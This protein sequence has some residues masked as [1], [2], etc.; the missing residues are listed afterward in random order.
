MSRGLYCYMI[1]T[2]NGN[3]KGDYDFVGIIIGITNWL[4]CGKWKTPFS[5]TLIVLKRRQ[6]RIWMKFLPTK[7]MAFL[8]IGKKKANYHN[9]LIIKSS[10]PP[11]SRARSGTVSLAIVHRQADKH[12]SL[13]RELKVPPIHFVAEG[14]LTTQRPGNTRFVHQ[15]VLHCF[16]RR[17]FGAKNRGGGAKPRRG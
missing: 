16:L 15:Q 5:P 4:P 14:H 6:F 17:N 2:K 13:T 3:G 9:K 10:P 7:I 1:P 8:Q 12:C 11:N